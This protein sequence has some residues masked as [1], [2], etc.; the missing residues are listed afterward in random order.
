MTK[1]KEPEISF[2]SDKGYKFLL[3]SEKVFLELIE[4]FVDKNWVEAIDKDAMIRIDKSY[5]LQDFDEKESDLVYRLKIKGREVIFYVL[6]EMQ[7]TVDFQMPY[8]L[9]SYMMEIWRDVLKNT[10]KEEAG[11]K[12]FRL[13]SIVP[14]VL[15]NGENN[16]TA[17][18]NYRE[19]LSEWEMFGEHVLNFKYVLVDV[20]RY[21]KQE[22]LKEASMIGAVFLFD[23]S[24]GN[25]EFVNRLGN[26]IEVLKKF[27]PEKL[28]LF[29]AWFKNIAVRELPED[30]KQ[31]V[32][33][34]INS[35]RTEE[36]ETMVHNLEKVFREYR[37]M[38]ERYN[39]AKTEGK[40]EGKMEGRLE[41]QIEVVRNLLSMGIDIAL[42]AK[43]VGTSEEDI[44]KIR[45]E[46][47]T[48]H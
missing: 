18:R 36:V 13:P 12:E 16:W 8:R 7:S 31:E 40:M 35:S 9:L 38:Y 33:E 15:Y 41:R 19:T 11:R 42:I 27:T 39:A 45:D 10:S 14:I 6:V 4:S 34:V 30:V 17:S 1:D 25:D 22:L 37:V 20:N 3:S 43:A 32:R 2:P 46:Q 28:Q 48:Q 26:T 47:D 29:K 21:S 44:V 23:Q 5:V 24:I